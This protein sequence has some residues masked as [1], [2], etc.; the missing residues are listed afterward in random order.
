MSNQIRNEY[1]HLVAHAEKATDN[2]RAVLKDARDTN[3]Y[4]K[5]KVAAKLV[6]FCEHEE[7]AMRLYAE[8]KMSMPELGDLIERHWPKFREVAEEARAKLNLEK[9]NG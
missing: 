7:K 3:D 1:D 6:E 9:G 4:W 2:A 5:E 8:A